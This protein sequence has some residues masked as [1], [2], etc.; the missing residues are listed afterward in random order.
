MS[1]KHKAELAYEVIRKADMD[2]I[3]FILK[4]KRFLKSRQIFPLH[5]AIYFS[6]MTSIIEIIKSG[7]FIDT[8][9]K[10]QGTA[11]HLAITSSEFYIARFLIKNGANLVRRNAK[12]ENAISLAC[13]FGDDAFIKY[14]LRNEKINFKRYIL[15]SRYGFYGFTLLGLLTDNPHIESA[16]TYRSLLLKGVDVSIRI[17]NCARFGDSDNFLT[18]VAAAGNNKL[19]LHLLKVVSGLSKIGKLTGRLDYNQT[20]NNGDSLIHLLAARGADQC[21]RF[22]LESGNIELNALNYSFKTP[23]NTG[24]QWGKGLAVSLLINSGCNI[25]LKS[26]WCLEYPVDQA[27]YDDDIQIANIIIKAGFDIKHS[28]NAKDIIAGKI[29]GITWRGSTNNVQ[30]LSCLARKKI[31]SELLRTN[32]SI[33]FNTIDRLPLPYSLKTYIYFLVPDGASKRWWER[34]RR[35][36]GKTNGSNPSGKR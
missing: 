9:N 35:K 17:A 28:S 6:N 11:L 5:V 1:P 13:K 21:L 2:N 22:V 3:E 33:N 23:L 36:N 26:L 16:L 10:I 29:P 31:R 24:I 15:N 25:Y 34:H 14:I 32:I 27:I 30:S 4:Q 7:Y 18:R 12:N 20:D 19:T 8:D